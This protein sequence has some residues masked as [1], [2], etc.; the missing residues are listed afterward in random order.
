MPKPDPQDEAR[1]ARMADN[2]LHARDYAKREDF[3]LSTSCFSYE[4]ATM[5]AAALRAQPERAAEEMR[6]QAINACETEIQ[7]IID[8]GKNAGTC[9]GYGRI[10]AS[11]IIHR[12]RRLRALPLSPAGGGG[13]E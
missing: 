11:N 13:G 3:L 8:L 4:E 2:I 6:S 7:Q 10:T 1:R 5:I 12:I 9:A